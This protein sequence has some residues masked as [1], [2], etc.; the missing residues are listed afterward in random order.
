[1]TPLERA[2]SAAILNLHEQAALTGC[3]TEDNGASVQIDGSFKL[4]PLVRAVLDAVREPSATMKTAGA[5]QR[6]YHGPEDVW[7]AM[8]EAML[9]D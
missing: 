4:E 6:V 5:R 7:R 2:I 1:M 9:A 8:V 3:T